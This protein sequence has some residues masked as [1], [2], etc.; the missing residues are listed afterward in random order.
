MKRLLPVMLVCGA[1]SASAFDM[2]RAA[3]E[4][5]ARQPALVAEKATADAEL[6]DLRADN[7][8]EGPEAEFEYKFP[9]GGGQNRWGLSVG[10]AFDWPGVYGARRNVARYRAGAFSE[11][12]RARLLETAL[13]VKLAMIRYAK[14]GEV[15]RMYESAADNFGRLYDIYQRALQRGETTIL[16]VRKIEIQ[17]FDVRMRLEACES[18]LAAAS[19]GLSALG[20]GEYA[21]SL[22]GTLEMPVL[23]PLAYYSEAMLEANPQMAAYAGLSQAENAS[24]SLARREALPSFT[25]SYVHDFEENTHFNGF[26]IGISLPTWNNR[27]RV[28][29][30]RARGEA[31]TAVLEDYKLRTSAELYADYSR[32]SQLFKNLSGFGDVFAGNGYTALLDKALDAG[33]ISLFDYLTEYYSFMESKISYYEVLADYCETEAR[34]GRYT[35]DRK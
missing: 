22:A 7:I 17:N 14:A 25:V 33:R 30:A 9:Q 10:Q 31:A 8:L 3:L 18:E 34:L 28:A 5:A 23:K 16:E 27:H 21:D 29:A 11:L 1:L 26:G 24:V 32:L 6:A 12:Y 35:I 15:K 13:E 4:I 2:D 19:A 20:A